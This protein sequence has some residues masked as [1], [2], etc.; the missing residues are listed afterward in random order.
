MI[1]RGPSNVRRNHAR[2]FIQT[3]AQ[4]RM[5]ETVKAYN[6]Q[7]SN[8]L[9]VNAVQIVLYQV[10]RQV[11]RPCSC[12]RTNVAIP[13]SVSN[14]TP[15]I[16]Q[17]DRATDGIEFGF[18]D[19]DI[20]GAESE[21]DQHMFN[22]VQ[23]RDVSGSQPD[24]G[25]RGIET[26]EYEDSVGQG[27]VNCGIC[28]RSLKQ[29]GYKAYGMQRTIYTH[30]DIERIEG[31]HLDSTSAPHAL[32]R[33][34][35]DGHVCFRLMIPKYFKSVIYSIREDLYVLR[36]KPLRKDGAIITID[37]LRRHAGQF[38]EIYVKS[39]RFTHVVFEFDM[40][41]PRINAN[42]GGE[43]TTLDYDRLQTMSD[44]PIV[45]GPEVSDVNEGDIVCIPERNLYLKIRDK[46]RKIM[47]DQARLEW[48][49]SS[50]VLQPT[51]PLRAIAKGYKLR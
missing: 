50:R 27:S 29:P 5:D 37:D 12:C 9:A 38:M 14:V 46:E 28:Y 45:L 48:V 49:C 34:H 13:G 31:Y 22:D 3:Q 30:Y 42:I 40:G 41:I 24:E 15:T 21:M 26:E 51:E 36:E 4:A 43:T 32:V 10:E 35:N 44:I 8:A 47:Q 2:N 7:V 16:P 33:E 39:E 6:H 11:G 19:D 20:F 23:V 25:L 1:K 18:Q 17:R